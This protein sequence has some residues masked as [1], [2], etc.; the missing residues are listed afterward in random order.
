M[1][2]RSD[3]LQT[4]SVT[5]KYMLCGPMAYIYTREDHKFGMCCLLRQHY[6]KSLK[7]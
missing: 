6:S 2:Q 5:A 3:T 1:V 7:K 4:V